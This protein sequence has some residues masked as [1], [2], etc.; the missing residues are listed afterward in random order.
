MFTRMIRQSLFKTARVTVW[1]LATLTACAALVTMFF[2][3]S[4][5]VEEKMRSSLRSLGANAVAYPVAQPVVHLQA[6]GTADPSAWAAAKELAKSKA[7]EILQIDLQVGSV[8]G[9]PVAIVTADARGLKRMTPYWAMKGRR[10]VDS[11]E[12]MVGRKLAEALKLSPGMTVD[13][14]FADRV[15]D[16]HY[17]VTG[18]FESGDE[19]E[20]RIFLSSQMRVQGANAFTYALLSIPGMEPDIAGLNEALEGMMAGIRIKPLRQ[21][22]H[23]EQTVLKKI[24]LLTGLT[25]LAVLILSSLGITAAV[26]SRVMERRKELALLQALGAKRRSVAI[27]L[28][29]EGAVVGISAAVLGYGIGNLLSLIVVREIFHV[30]VTPHLTAFLAVAVVTV[31]IAL[32]AGFVAAR[33][34]LRMETVVLLKGE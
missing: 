16:R 3:I 7:A 31:G 8:Q 34:A 18:V 14:Q 17:R 4:M 13:I 23:G 27:F 2:T 32:F 28:L 21:V 9:T 24:N 30:S 22:L 12:C 15:E 6:V 33:Q 1:S 11:D 5:D 25:L 26:F 29:S 19:D 10:A 20:D